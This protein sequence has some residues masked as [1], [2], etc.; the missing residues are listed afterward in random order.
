M[1]YQITIRVAEENK[2]L[3]KAILPDVDIQAKGD[4]IVEEEDCFEKT[5]L[6]VEALDK[7]E[8]LEKTKEDE[9]LAKINE[10]KKYFCEHRNE[11]ILEFVFPKRMERWK[12]S[13]SE[14]E[15]KNKFPAKKEEISEMIHLFINEVFITNED[16]LEEDEYYINPKWKIYAYLLTEGKSSDEMICLYL[17]LW[18]E[19]FQP[20]AEE[21][22]SEGLLEKDEEWYSAK[23]VKC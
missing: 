21:A 16:G 7:N 22:I 15:L 18:P 12:C 2:K 1:K 20:I 17:S 9:K 14:E 23:V 8:I 3:L 6:I 4:I 19:H 10:I 13:T 11:A 5:R